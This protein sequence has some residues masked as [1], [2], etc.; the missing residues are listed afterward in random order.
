[1]PESRQWPGP[2]RKFGLFDA[3]G[4]ECRR[5]LADAISAQLV[6]GVDGQLGV[7]LA[8]DFALF[9]EGAGDDVNVGAPGDVVRDGAAVVSVSSS[10]WAWTKSRRGASVE[11]IEPEH[12]GAVDQAAVQR[13]ASKLALTRIAS[14]RKRE[15]ASDLGWSRNRQYKGIFDRK[16]LTTLCSTGTLVDCYGSIG[17][18]GLT[19]LFDN[20]ANV[21]RGRSPCNEICANR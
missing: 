11:V 21:L 12:T 13:G 3:E 1:M 5:Q 16:W 17:E 9:A 4:F 18:I 8:D 7:L 19:K 10:G 15:A 2:P 14:Q 20:W 6:G